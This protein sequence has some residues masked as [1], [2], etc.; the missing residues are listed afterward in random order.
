M[1]VTSLVSSLMSFETTIW[2]LT[3]LAPAASLVLA[4]LNVTRAYK[5]NYGLLIGDAEEVRHY[6]TRITAVEVPLT[7]VLWLL[8]RLTAGAT[9]RAMEE[10]NA[11]VLAWAVTW[12]AL[13]P[14]VLLAVLAVEA[15]TLYKVL[16]MSTHCLCEECYMSNF[17]DCASCTGFIR[18]QVEDGS[19][20]VYLILAAAF[21]ASVA[22]FVGYALVSL[23]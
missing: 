21:G 12:L 11:F 7:T 10:G 17:Y 3:V 18:D 15:L 19:L 16:M 4:A 5:T 14:E 1:S 23:A 2:L 22:P 13:V 20:D 8:A 9:A 6:M